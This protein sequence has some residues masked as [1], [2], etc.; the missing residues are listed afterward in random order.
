MRWSSD[1]HLLVIRLDANDVMDSGFCRQNFILYLKTINL[2]NPKMLSLVSHKTVIRRSWKGHPSSF[3]APV[4]KFISVSKESS[5]YH[6]LVFLRNIW[7][8]W[9]ISCSLC[10]DVTLYCQLNF[11]FLLSFLWITALAT[12]IIIQ[13]KLFKIKWKKKTD[14]EVKRLW[15]HTVK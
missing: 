2:F 3:S 8:Y 13:L 4:W 7:Q 14:K 6:Y 5:I 9:L 11:P 1:G 10:F 15:K 12:V